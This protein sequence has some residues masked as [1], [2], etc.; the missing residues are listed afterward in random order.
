VKPPDKLLRPERASDAELRRLWA[1]ARARAGKRPPELPPKGSLAYQIILAGMKARGERWG[2]PRAKP[3][4]AP[5]RARGTEVIAALREYS[6]A[7]GDLRFHHAILAVEQHG[8]HNMNAGSLKKAGRFSRV[9]LEHVY[10][11]RLLDTGEVKSERE[12]AKYT[13]AAWGSDG[14]SFDAAVKALVDGFRK[15]VYASQKK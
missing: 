13:A 5:R 8:F 1:A 10:M 4:K 14:H 2:T 15:S 7:T 11:A 6:R 12:A 9:E 3:P